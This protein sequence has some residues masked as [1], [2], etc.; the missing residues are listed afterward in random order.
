MPN[1]FD[2]I[3]TQTLSVASSAINIAMPTGYTDVQINFSIRSD[4]SGQLADGANIY[5]NSDTT[6]ANYRRATLYDENGAIGGETNYNGPQFGVAPAANA[7]SNVYLCGTIYI[8]NYAGS[9]RKII[10]GFSQFTNPGTATRYMWQT[11]LNWS[12]TSPIT[13]VRISSADSA[14]YIVGSEITLYGI[15]KA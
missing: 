3:G 6:G 2:L 10:R 7:V 4:R 13:T 11:M 12:G 1:T 15:K 14:N 8:P 9:G 5:L